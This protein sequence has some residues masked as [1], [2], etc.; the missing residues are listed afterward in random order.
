MSK[1]QILNK[2]KAMVAAIPADP[3]ALKKLK[4][5]LGIIIATFAFLLYAQSIQYYYTLDDHA[6]ID[7][8]KYTKMGF[9]GI[10]TLIKTDYLYGVN[11]GLDR[12]PV[13]RPI[14]IIMFAIEWSFFP[15]NAHINH[16][17]NVLLYSISCSVLFILLC[18]IFNKLNLLF[19]FICT[20]LFAAHPIH[21]EVVNNIKSR[22][23]IL[24]FLFGILSI[25]YFIKSISKQSILYIILGSISF[26][27]AMLSKETG[28]TFLIVIPLTI[29]IFMV[30]L[31]ILWEII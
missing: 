20:L 10:P 5:S 29:F 19:P 26:F 15:N 22:D 21:T 3:N 1:K 9:A 27:L 12:G 6:V 13:Y 30:L 11:N 25:F 18:K 17:M 28:V 14:S 16:F 2:Q 24:C 23:E 7:Q 31:G 4:I 8:N